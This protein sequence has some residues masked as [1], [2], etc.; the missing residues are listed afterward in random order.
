MIC[1]LSA[2]QLDRPAD[3]FQETLHVNLG[4]EQEDGQKG[5]RFW[6]G[7]KDTFILSLGPEVGTDS[8]KA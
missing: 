1:R 6:E 2:L 4:T 7:I 8:Q 5:S 3:V